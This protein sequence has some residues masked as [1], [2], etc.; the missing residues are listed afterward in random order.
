MSINALRFKHCFYERRETLDWVFR[1]T[2]G[3]V[4]ARIRLDVPLGDVNSEDRMMHAFCQRRYFAYESWR[5]GTRIKWLL[6]T[7]VAYSVNERGIIVG[8]YNI[9]WIV[10]YERFK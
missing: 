10:I 6:I 2:K 4:Y 8:D 5:C 7:S 1:N 3:D 9:L